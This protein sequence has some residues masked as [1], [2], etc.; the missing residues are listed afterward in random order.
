MIELI[1][2]VLFAALEAVG[3]VGSAVLEWLDRRPPP[4][5]RNA[6]TQA[7]LARGKRRKGRKSVNQAGTP[8]A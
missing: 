5:A 2:Y 3:W 1:L 7:V 4:T 8:I 6:R